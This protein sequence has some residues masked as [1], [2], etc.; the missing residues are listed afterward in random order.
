MEGRRLESENHVDVFLLDDGFQHQQLARALDI[1]LVDS[2]VCLS[3]EWMLPAG[4][5]REP[6]SALRRAT[7]TV[8]TR[9]H[10]ES[11]E[12]VHNKQIKKTSGPRTSTEETKVL[13][14]RRV[15]N[16]KLEQAINRDLPP[17][18]VFA[19]CG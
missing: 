3:K 15:S 2:T 17:Q 13:G 16:G 1:V 6:I 12:C 7:A 4:G 9:G 11:S 14:S 19:F 10:G 18:P 8:L 5:M